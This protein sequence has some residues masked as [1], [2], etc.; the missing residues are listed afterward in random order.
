MVTRDGEQYLHVKDLKWAL[1]AGTSRFQFNNL[2]G[3]DKALGKHSSVQDDS[4]GRGPSSQ[5]CSDN[6][7]SRNVQ[8]ASDIHAVK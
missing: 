8:I 5:S 3:G 7:V 1:G 4:P 2:F 6:V